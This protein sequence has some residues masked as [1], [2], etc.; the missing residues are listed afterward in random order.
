VAAIDDTG[1]T[2]LQRGVLARGLPPIDIPSVAFPLLDAHVKR[3]AQTDTRPVLALMPD[4]RGFV[5]PAWV[6]EVEKHEIAQRMLI[7]RT[8]RTGENITGGLFGALGYWLGGDEGSDVGAALDAM[9]V[10]ASPHPLNEQR[11]VGAPTDVVHGAPT[12]ERSTLPGEA[13]PLPP[14]ER[15]P[16]LR[17]RDLRTREPAR[18]SAPVPAKQR[19]MTPPPQGTPESRRTEDRLG[20]P[21]RPARPAR[22][23]R[24]CP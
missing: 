17:E 13:P 10:I 4:G 24:K 5:G 6:A 23:D 7:E 1:L 15:E 12:H 22:S 14:A 20:P 8:I 3:D 16:P 2:D 9:T 11:V 19:T 21:P 18:A